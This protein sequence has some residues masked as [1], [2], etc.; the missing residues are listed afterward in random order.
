MCLHADSINSTISIFQVFD[1][2]VDSIRFVL[3]VSDPR[4]DSI[5]VIEHFLIVFTCS[6]GSF[7]N[8]TRKVW[9]VAPW[10]SFNGFVMMVTDSFV[11]SIPSERVLTDGFNGVGNICEHELFKLCKVGH[12]VY[13]WWVSGISRCPNEVMSSHRHGVLCHVRSELF[14]C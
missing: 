13:P 6:S 9:N 14:T 10:R 12:G 1:V 7:E 2:I 3:L 4:N 5:I 8:F 11:D